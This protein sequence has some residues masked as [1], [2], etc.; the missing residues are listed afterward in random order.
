MFLPNVG[1]YPHG[2]T[3]PEGQHRHLLPFYHV[4]ATHYA[5]LVVDGCHLVIGSCE[6]AEQAGAVSQKQMSLRFWN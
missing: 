4:S 3:S 1:V 6:Y 2:V 5:F